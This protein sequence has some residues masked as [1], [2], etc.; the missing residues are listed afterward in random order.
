MALRML[1]GNPAEG[2][3]NGR[4]FVEFIRQKVLLPDPT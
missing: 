2:A 4:E 3:L 1:I